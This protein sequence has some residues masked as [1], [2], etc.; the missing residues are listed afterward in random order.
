MDSIAATG[1]DVAQRIP[2]CLRP[3]LLIV[4]MQSTSPPERVL[5]G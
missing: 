4:N 3:P 1:V 5:S 2:F